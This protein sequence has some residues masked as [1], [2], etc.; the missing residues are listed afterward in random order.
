MT[1]ALAILYLAGCGG[2]TQK[3]Q[4]EEKIEFETNAQVAEK[5]PVIY[6]VVAINHEVKDWG[7]WR[8]AYDEHQ[9][10]RE[11]AG[12]EELD[13]LRDLDNRNE[14][15]IILRSRNHETARDFSS[16]NDLK[17]AMER[18]GVG[19]EPQ[20]WYWNVVQARENEVA[21]W[22]YRLLISHEVRDFKAWK[23][24]FDGHESSR[25]EA[26]I[27]ILGVA[28]DREKPN[29]VSIMFAFDDL[30]KAQKYAASED[31]R[32][33]M[34]EAGVISQPGMKWMVVPDQDS[35]I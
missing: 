7:A 12:L 33:R 27:N 31:L 23:P 1:V 15:M 13:V 20:I 5:V 28:R 4:T 14:V 11:E 19:T 2:G 9:S 35:V 22:K 29:L 10:N 30:E 8:Q 16:S 17:E 18:A 32:V 3:N 21:S 26:G 24:M 34:D 25:Q 6:T